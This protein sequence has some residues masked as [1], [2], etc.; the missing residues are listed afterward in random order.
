MV[1][2][3]ILPERNKPKRIDA[4]E[5]IKRIMFVLD[6]YP[7]L[8]LAQDFVKDYRLDKYL[9]YWLGFEQY[10]KIEEETINRAKTLFRRPNNPKDMSGNAAI[11]EMLERIYKLQCVGT[12]VLKLLDDV[13]ASMEKEEIIVS[14]PEVII[15]EESNREDMNLS[16]Q[17]IVDNFDSYDRL[18][19][20]NLDLNLVPGKYAVIKFD[21]KS[22][23]SKLRPVLILARQTGTDTFDYPIA[24]CD[25]KY[26][27]VLIQR[28]FP[29]PYMIQ[30]DKVRY[31][32]IEER[33]NKI[34]R[35]YMHITTDKPL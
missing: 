29:F 19:M 28:A 1:D 25:K 27:I 17:G 7:D 10:Q 26:I 4:E 33:I 8:Q 21:D 34:G 2:I 15:I 16:L 9:I 32:D 12:D 13:I 30:L 35:P 23:N 11:I 3:E 14:T 18:A 20:R 24:I 6:L 5:K 22:I 31:V